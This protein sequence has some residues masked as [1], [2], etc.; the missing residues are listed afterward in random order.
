MNH[1]PFFVVLPRG[2]ARGLQAGLPSRL[3]K[4]G[5]IHNTAARQAPPRGSS[6]DLVW[7][8]SGR[9]SRRFDQ[10]YKP[11]STTN[12]RQKAALTP[13]GPK[14]PGGGRAAKSGP[15]GRAAPRAQRARAEPRRARTPRPQAGG[16][17]RGTRGGGRGP[18]R[19]KAEPGDG[20]R[21][22][23]QGARRA[24]QGEAQAPTGKDPQ[25]APSG[26]CRKGAEPGR[27]PARRRGPP[28]GAHAGAR[29]RAPAP[30]GRGSERGTKRAV[31]RSG[32]RSPSGRGPSRPKA[33]AGK[34]AAK[35]RT[36]ARSTA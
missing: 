13:R 27:G 26:A 30:K 9:R 7:L 10:S 18:E 36:R 22:T 14:S 24:P 1:S 4:P 17:R 15:Q 28:G 5:R 11:S 20:P 21:A 12:C 3:D 31:P 34:P 19:A 32:S 25:R 2:N 6:S 23:A 16:G 29:R 8:I 35:G 33:G